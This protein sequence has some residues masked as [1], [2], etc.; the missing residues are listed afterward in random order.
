MAQEKTGSGTGGGQEPSPGQG[1][2]IFGGLKKLR[3][4][5]QNLTSLAGPII[6]QPQFNFSPLRPSKD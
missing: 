6:F 3:F 4:E 1:R 2:R 5:D